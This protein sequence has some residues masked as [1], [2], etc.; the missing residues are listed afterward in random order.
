LEET[1]CKTIAA[2]YCTNRF[3][4]VAGTREE[5]PMKIELAKEDV[6]L[7]NMLLEKNLGETLVGIHHCKTNDYKDM[8][9]SRERQLRNLLEQFK[10]MSET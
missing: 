5:I 3:P 2:D 10:P 6:E 9:R 4:E 1:E 7:I 8:L